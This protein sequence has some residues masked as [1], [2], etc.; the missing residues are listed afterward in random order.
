MWN[1]YIQVLDYTWYVDNGFQSC[2]LYSVWILHSS[3]FKI[4]LVT[5]LTWLIVKLLFFPLLPHPAFLFSISWVHNHVLDFFTLTWNL[6]Y[7]PLNIK[8]H[9]K[10]LTKGK[11]ICPSI[12]VT[13]SQNASTNY[14]II[15]YCDAL[16][17]F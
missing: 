14:Y 2:D 15:Y 7:F 16:L 12:S 1:D 3:L 9:K 13:P 10:C 4:Q 5:T 8:T 17:C 11:L 6:I